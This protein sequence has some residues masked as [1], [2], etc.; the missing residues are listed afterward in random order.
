MR[1]TYLK[2]NSYILVQGYPD[3]F[4]LGDALNI[5]IIEYL[6]EKKVIFAKYIPNSKYSKRQSYAVI[7]SIIQWASAET[8]IWGAGLIS[9]KDEQLP[10]FLVHAVRGPL[11]REKLLRNNI[12]CPEVY[13]DPALLLPLLYQPP[14]AFNKFKFGIIPHYVD[15]GHPWLKKMAMRDDIRIIDLEVGTNYKSVIDDIMQCENILTTSLHGM[16]LSY[17]Y[18][19]PLCHIQLSDKIEGGNFKFDDFLLSI[20]KSRTEP[21][22]IVDTMQPEDLLQFIDHEKMFFDYEPLLSSCPFITSDIQKLLIS[23]AINQ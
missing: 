22:I 19:K 10:D 15:K 5:P 14:Q 1:F 2:P 3:S 11:T 7:G 8:N 6:S 13:G 4:N 23:K 12:K 16:I 17:A 18:K 20:N 21:I 9:D